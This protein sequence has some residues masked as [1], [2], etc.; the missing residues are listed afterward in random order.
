MLCEF[1][2]ND[3]LFKMLWQ[4]A[5]DF[6]SFLFSHSIRNKFKIQ[7]HD[8]SRPISRPGNHSPY[9]NRITPQ[10]GLFRHP[11]VSLPPL[12]LPRA[13]TNT[14]TRALFLRCDGVRA[15]ANDKKKTN[16]R[17]LALANRFPRAA[18]GRAKSDKTKPQQAI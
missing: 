7:I 2:R 9:P 3:N 6:R 15:S 17:A 14:K 8:L 11:A 16:E 12:V 18:T 4:K 1:Q 13:N 10:T 5:I